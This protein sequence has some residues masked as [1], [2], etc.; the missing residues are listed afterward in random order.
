MQIPRLKAEQH[1]AFIIA[2]DTSLNSLAAAGIEA[3]AV[4]SIDC[5]HYSCYHFMNGMPPIPLFLDLA[6]PPLL[7]A[8]AGR[9]YFFAGGHPLAA[10][11]SRFWRSFPPVDTSGGN[12]TYAAVCLAESIGAKK[13]ELYGA[14]FSYPLGWTY[15]RGAY[16][17]PSFA[18]RQKRLLPF[19][20]LHSDLLY[21]TPLVK[22]AGKGGVFYYET[23]AM[24]MYRERLEEKSALLRTELIPVPGMGAPVNVCTRRRQG[25]PSPLIWGKPSLRA[26]DFLAGYQDRIR[27]LPLPGK[28]VSAWLEKLNLEERFI[29]ATLLP[30]AAALKRRS[31]ELKTGALI[32]AAAAYC[33]AEIEKVLNAVKSEGEQQGTR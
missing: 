24:R 4:V 29:L 13:I 15:T 31:P 14:D 10:Y 27:A 32:E 6:S 3:H 19:E 21:R 23:P 11:V 17:F 7:A 33:R 8:M 2:T 28:G 1:T 18:Q 22:K 25:K 5:Q 12:V 16:I 30:E 26:E 20:T 9:R